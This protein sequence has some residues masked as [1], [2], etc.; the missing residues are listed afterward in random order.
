MQRTLNKKLP[1]LHWWANEGAHTI[2]ILE[3]DDIALTNQVAVFEALRVNLPD[4]S[5]RPDYVFYVDTTGSTWIIHPLIIE[6][7]FSEFPYPWPYQ[8]FNVDDLSDILFHGQQ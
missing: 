4:Q 2:L 5:F 3:S 7:Q 1:K 8:E 6:R